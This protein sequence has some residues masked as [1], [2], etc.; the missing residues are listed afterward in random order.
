VTNSIRRNEFPAAEKY[1]V[2]DLLPGVH[3]VRVDAI[4]SSNIISEGR[5]VIEVELL[6][7]MEK[8]HTGLSL[9]IK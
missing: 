7:D 5:E 2:R 3:L 4:S 1:K 8:L 6:P 9:R